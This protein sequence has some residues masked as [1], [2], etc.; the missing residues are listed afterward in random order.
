MIHEFDTV[1]VLRL[2]EGKPALGSESVLRGP[3][4]DDTGIVVAIRETEWGETVYTVERVTSDGRTEWLAD[5]RR[6]EIELVVGL[7]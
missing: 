1:K 6:A 4:I 5:F 7:S 3:E 2:L